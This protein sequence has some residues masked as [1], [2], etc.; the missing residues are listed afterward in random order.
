M[1]GNSKNTDSAERVSTKPIKREASRT[2]SD[3][4]KTLTDTSTGELSETSQPCQKLWLSASLLYGFWASGIWKD[5]QS[6]LTKSTNNSLFTE[7]TLKVVK[8]EWKDST[9]ELLSSHPTFGTLS[10]KAHLWPTKSNST[11]LGD[12]ILERNS[13]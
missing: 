7:R 5:T 8:V 1:I 3:S 9:R 11:L 10:S 6:L 2:C 12:K 13:N 4:L